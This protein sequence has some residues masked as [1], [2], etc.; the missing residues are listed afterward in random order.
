VQLFDVFSSNLALYRK[1]LAG[2][3]MCPLCLRTFSRNQISS[4][5][6]KAHIIPQSLGGR[7]WTLTCRVCNNRVG[8]EIESYEAERDRFRRAGSG[9]CAETV[10]FRFSVCDKGGSAIGSVRAEGRVVEKNGQ[11]R[12]Q[13][14]LSDRR[15]HPGAKKALT[16]QISSGGYAIEASS[17][18]TRNRERANLTYVHAAYLYMFHQFGYEWV[19]SPGAGTIRNQ[20]DSPDEPIITPLF[21]AFDG[22]ETPEDKFELRLVTEPASF[23]SLLLIM[24]L[25][26]DCSK[27]QGVWIPLFGRPYTQPPVGRVG[28]KMEHIPDHH[29]HLHKPESYL[30]GTRLISDRFAY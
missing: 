17:L 27:R 29:Q 28:L 23:R 24:P 18:V 20:I 19:F 4:D 8:S 11:R 14:Q 12:L 21:P 13:I 1:E 26:W 6:G 25:S 7:E 16:D 2:R 30:Q 15:S 9:S 3:F 22:I 5:L 10:D